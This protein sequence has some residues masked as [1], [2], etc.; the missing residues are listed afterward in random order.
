MSEIKKNDH[1]ELFLDA[2]SIMI[3][4]EPTDLRLQIDG[5]TSLIKTSYGADP[6]KNIFVFLNRKRNKIKILAWHYNGFVLLYKRL[7]KDHHFFN[8]VGKKNKPV[9]M[10]KEQLSWLISG[11]DWI[12]MSAFG[13]LEY[14]D[15]K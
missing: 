14:K 11:L 15:Y 3:S 4:T 10:T 9:K 1:A 8:V 5:L 13:E 2:P 7:E 12:T 6:Y